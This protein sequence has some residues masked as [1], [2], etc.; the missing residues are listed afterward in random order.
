MTGEI[1]AALLGGGS[2]VAII[3]GFLLRLASRYAWLKAFT[4]RIERYRR[5]VVLDVQNTYVQALKDRRADGK[6][7]PE[8]AR[9]ALGM[10]VDRFLELLGV[11]AV[12]RYLALAGLP[13]TPEFIER[14][15]RTLVEA[16]VKEL[17]IDEAAANGAPAVK[18]AAATAVA[19]QRASAELAAVRPGGP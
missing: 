9:E 10:A 2:L 17:S 4:D 5:A 8:E 14:W 13:K 18:V 1:L 16:A 11:K 3:G 7:T 15:A 6:L 12:D 19:V